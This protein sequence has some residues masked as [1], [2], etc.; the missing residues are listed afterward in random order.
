ML[1]QSGNPKQPSDRPLLMRPCVVDPS[2]SSAFMH[3]I[4]PSL[5]NATYFA[6]PSSLTLRRAA[7]M[8]MRAH[9]PMFQAS[10]SV[11][12]SGVSPAEW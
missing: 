9:Q 4:I 12:F 3:L 5:P 8:P 11:V 6:P 2:G 1:K 10:L 7:S